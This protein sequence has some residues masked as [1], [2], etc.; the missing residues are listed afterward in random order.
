MDHAEAKQ[1]L[2]ET[3]AEVL[4]DEDSGT[5]RINGELTIQELHAVLQ[6][7]EYTA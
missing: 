6:L 1:I 7:L 5:A 4:I 3:D 2:A